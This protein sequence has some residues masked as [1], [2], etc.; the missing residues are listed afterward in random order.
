M[1]ADK[2]RKLNNKDAVREASKNFRVLAKNSR[3][4][5]VKNKTPILRNLRR[6]SRPLRGIKKLLGKYTLNLESLSYSPSRDV[7]DPN[8]EDNIRG[9][10]ACY[11]TLDDEGKSI[12]FLRDIIEEYPLDYDFSALEQ[13]YT[14]VEP[15]ETRKTD[16]Q[17]LKQ[18]LCDE[19]VGSDDT[20]YEEFL[21]DDFE[22]IEEFFTIN[23]VD[24]H[25]AYDVKSPNT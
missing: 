6:V 25:P 20:H 21:P 14:L 2:F 17:K 15:S 8:V 12:K 11:W 13:A 10:T 22:E 9:R 5:R 16:S 24:T 1:T 23:P 18:V 4:T 7:L 19:G 3:V